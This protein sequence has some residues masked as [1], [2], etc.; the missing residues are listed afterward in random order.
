M[1]RR[2]SLEDCVKAVGQFVDHPVDDPKFPTNTIAPGPV[3]FVQIIESLF[4]S[5]N[6]NPSDRFV[7]T[8]VGVVKKKIDKRFM[9][10]ME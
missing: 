6:Q 10:G 3:V 1:S 7:P 2:I 4:N 9:E 5:T 8:F